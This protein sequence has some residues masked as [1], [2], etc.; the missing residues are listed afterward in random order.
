[1]SISRSRAQPNTN[2]ATTEHTCA[3]QISPFF[4]EIIS[5]FPQPLVAVN[6]NVT[7]H[8]ERRSFL[9][10][11]RKK[12]AVFYLSSTSFLTSVVTCRHPV[13]QFR[14]HLF[15]LRP[16]K[17]FF[18]RYIFEILTKQKRT[19]IR[20]LFQASV[21]E[22][23]FRS[24]FHRKKWRL[25]MDK[26]VCHKPRGLFSPTFAARRNRVNQNDQNTVLRLI[27]EYL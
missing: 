3:Q 22:S 6:Q 19:K 23:R 11:A 1:M 15:L 25:M 16:R 9:F 26:T 18:R 7:K 2:L 12:A 24:R 17:L 4:R 13:F 21:S 10:P 27:A 20:Y 5:F 8:D 14:T